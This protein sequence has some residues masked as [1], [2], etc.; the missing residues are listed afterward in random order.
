VIAVALLALLAGCTGIEE[1]APA[2]APQVEAPPVQE[3]APPQEVPHR[4]VQEPTPV[5][6]QAPSVEEANF[7]LLWS[8][9]TGEPVYG[10][11]A[12]RRYVAIASYDNRVHLLSADG[13]HLWSFETAGNAEAVAL[14]KGERYLAASSYL[15]PE[16]RLY[17]FAISNGTARLLWEKEVDTPVRAV[18]LSE[19][20]G[21]V[22]AGTGR[23]E[24]LAYSLTGAP[25]WSFRIGDSAWG[26]WDLE[27]LG[28]RVAV[29]GDDTF[30]YLLSA[31]G[32]LLW[33]RGGGRR[34]YFYGCDLYG[35]LVA[36][37]TQDRMVRLYSEEGRLLWSFR[38]EF[39]NYDAAISG[40]LVA[41][42]SWDNRVYILSHGGEL[43]QVLEFESE[44]TELDFSPGGD[45][46]AVGSRD[47]RVYVFTEK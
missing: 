9:D 3:E 44:P 5:E 26:V 17:L 36:G 18:A 31:E 39:S 37:V 28:D 43:L 34:G 47:G 24:V 33:K 7:S 12:G 4:E 23:G 16:A 42:S 11:D 10:V 1:P 38:T 14:G 15:I 21:L 22:V 13:T 19:A 25:R 46:L 40:E 35:G 6:E 20:L 32:E 27:L 29:A 30:L 2:K 41:V 8:F 45:I